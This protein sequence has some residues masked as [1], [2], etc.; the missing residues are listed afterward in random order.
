MLWVFG[1]DVFQFFAN[2]WVTYWKYFLGKGSKVLKTVYIKIWSHDAFQ[3]MVLRLPWGQKRMFWSFRNGIFHFLPSF[4]W[5]NW[6]HFLGKRDKAL[7]TWTFENDI[8]QFFFK[9]L[10]DEVE[11]IYWTSEAKRSKLFKSKFG[12]RKFF[13]NLFWSYLKVKNE[14]SQRLEM[15][16]FTFW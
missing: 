6:N 3:K 10:N 9:F 8:F 1:N 16:F 11:T 5:Q 13:R 14:C 4:K 7:K 15:T 2:F 12:H